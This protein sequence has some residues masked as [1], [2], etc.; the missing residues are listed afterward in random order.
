MEC[1]Y[2]IHNLI[3]ITA[4]YNIYNTHLGNVVFAILQVRL[5]YMM[6]LLLQ[7]AR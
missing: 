2:I 6:N 7:R 3:L 4:N 5:Q 1:K